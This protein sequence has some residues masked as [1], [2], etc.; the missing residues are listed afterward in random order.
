[1]TF[2]IAVEHINIARPNV[3]YR[4]SNNYCK[5]FFVEIMNAVTAIITIRQAASLSAV[6][7]CAVQTSKTTDK[8]RM[9]KASFIDTK[10]K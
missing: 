1:M 10:S 6:H 9:Q 3:V 2:L 4:L 5:L 7:V 8:Q